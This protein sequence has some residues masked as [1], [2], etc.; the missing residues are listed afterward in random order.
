MLSERRALLK[1][2]KEHEYS[3]IVKANM[4]VEEQNFTDMLTEAM[5]ALGYSEQ[6][7]DAT[8]VHAEPSDP[9]HHDAG[10]V[11][12]SRDRRSNHSRKR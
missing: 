4:Q 6:D 9:S 7:D 10:L 1:Q 5:D 2:G 12:S 3:E 11:C 8:T